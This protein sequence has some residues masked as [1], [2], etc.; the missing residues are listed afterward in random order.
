MIY[1]ANNVLLF[2]FILAG[3]ATWT[4]FMGGRWRREKMVVSAKRSAIALLVLSS[5]LIIILLSAFIRRDFSLE[6]VAAYSNRTLP[7]VYT[8]SAL[9]AGQAGSLLVWTWLLCLF[10]VLV[11][12]QNREKNRDLL[13][14]VLG[15]LFATAFFFFGLIVYSTSPFELLPRP[16]TE[17]SGLNPMLQNAGMLMH[18]PT[19]FVGYVGFTVPFAFAIAALIRNRLD[20]QWIQS[21]RRW[22]IVSWLFLTL[23]NLLGAKWAYVELG[24]GGYWAWDPVENA[25]L[26]PWLTGTAFLHSVMIQEKRGMLKTW[27]VVLI[28]LTFSLTIFGTFITRSGIISSVHSFG[29]SNLGPLFLLFLLLILVVSSGL[30][31]YRRPGLQSDNQ[32]DG[33]ISRESSFLFNNLI[34]LGMAFAVFWGTIFPIISEAV[35]GV[36]VTVGPPYYNQVN[37]PI[38]LA[39][40][41][42]TGICPLIAWRK[43]S[44]KNLRRS[45]VIPL[46]S[47][48]VTAGGL[49]IGGFYSL[50]PVM[51]FSLAALVL[52]TIMLEFYRGSVTRS[53]I[54]RVSLIHGLWDLTMRNKRRYGGYIVHLGVTMIFVGIAGSGAFQKEVSTVLAV[55]ESTRIADYTLNYKGIVDQS[56]DHARIV[57]AE[58]EVELDGK[59]IATMFP[60]KQIYRNQ[61]PVSE[62]DI[63]QTLKEDLYLILAQ[64]DEHQ[65]VTIKALV[66]PLVAWIWI[67]GVV[68]M[69]GTLVALGPERMSLT[70]RSVS[71]PAIKADEEMEKQNA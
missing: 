53:R 50:Y 13:P 49:L 5:I 4:A 57:A 45:F 29:V 1:V 17:G 68:M 58:F 16:A 37:I 30:L 21:T 51:S 38:G 3:Y 64:W 54:L 31:W 52:T 15:V 65:N 35:K 20:A 24:W 11:V 66:I 36:K 46:L 22:T 70:N 61:D 33:F 27:N 60:S 43:A 23:G 47:G 10:S 19:L 42:L 63:R 7:L 12:W 56:T 39:L 69:I 28:V 34:L 55:G 44:M 59:T 26:M 62:V 8:V 48:L 32:F 18:P 6:Y 67:G 2:S 41:A 14:F 9:W 40:L 71:V 25:S